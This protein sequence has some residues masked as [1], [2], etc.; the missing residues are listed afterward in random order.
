MNECYKNAAVGR[1]Q[2]LAQRKEVKKLE[3][4]PLR[5]PP[6]MGRIAGFKAERQKL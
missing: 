2:R 4:T 5:S 1:L 6:E 3:G